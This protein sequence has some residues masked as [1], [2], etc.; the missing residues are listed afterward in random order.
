MIVPGIILLIAMYFGKNFLSY[1]LD[2]NQAHNLK[3]CGKLRKSIKAKDV[4]FPKSK[5]DSI[6]DEELLSIIYTIEAS[7]NKKDLNNFHRNIKNLKIERLDNLDDYFLNT[8][9]GLYYGGG[10]ATF[11][12]KMY[13]KR[14]E[15]STS[16]EVMHLSS[17]NNNK[18][19]RYLLTGFQQINKVKPNI[20]EGLNEGYTEYLN[21]LLFENINGPVES[22]SIYIFEPIVAR[23]IED[24]VGTNK[25]QSLYFNADLNGLYDALSSYLT[26]KETDE[27]II[28]LDNINRYI[29]DPDLEEDD[30]KALT[31]SCSKVVLLVN[32]ILIKKMKEEN[33]DERFVY[34]YFTNMNNIKEVLTYTNEEHYK[35]IISF[36]D[37]QEDIIFDFVNGKAV[38]MPKENMKRMKE[39]RIVYDK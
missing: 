12:N 30:D 33:Y 17:S 9:K 22:N 15:P 14:G 26:E 28:G 1:A 29:N 23:S 10:Y 3:R 31:K 19:L 5:V 38:D 2:Y 16:H 21:K 35:D 18:R 4:E 27:L 37:E 24:V 7:F 36:I 32:K 6:T 39:Y 34:R 13:I 11:S 20:G 25:M 8:T